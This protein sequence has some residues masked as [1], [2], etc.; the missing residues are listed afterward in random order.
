[1]IVGIGTDICDISRIEKTIQRQ[2]RFVERVL[3]EQEIAQFKQRKRPAAF[4]ASRFA[5]KEAAL[6]ALGTGLANGIR[7]QDIEISHLDSGQP[8]LAFSGQALVIAEEKQV[9]SMHLSISD[10]QSYAVAF[11]VLESNLAV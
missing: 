9:T 5:A 1:M 7:W 10:E 3:T 6:K 11:V 2:D 4:V 8:I